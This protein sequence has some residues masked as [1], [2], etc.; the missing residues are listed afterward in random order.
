[1]NNERNGDRHGDTARPSLNAAVQRR[2]ADRDF[3]L[4]VRDAIFQ[5][6]RALERLGK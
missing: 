5:N 4:R 3:F 2:R 1:V 6:H